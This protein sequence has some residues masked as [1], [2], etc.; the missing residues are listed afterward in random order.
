MLDGFYLPPKPAIIVPSEGRGPFAALSLDL[1]RR[2]VPRNVRRA[3]VREIER[4]AGQ[5]PTIIRPAFADLERFAKAPIHALGAGAAAFPLNPGT[6]YTTLL[7]HGNG[8]NNGTTFTDSSPGA[9]S[10]S[11]GAGSPV[12]DTGTVKFGSASIKIPDTASYIS[13]A[14]HA[15]FAFG[16]ADFTVDFWL[17]LPS[18]PASQ[19]AGVVS[20]WSISSNAGDWRF[21]FDSAATPK[22]NFGNNVSTVVMGTLSNTTWHHIAA[23]RSGTTTRGFVDGVQQGGDQTGDNDNIGST[24][25]L[26]LGELFVTGSARS[27]ACYIDEVRVSKGIARWTSNF[28]P[29]SGEYSLD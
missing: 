27:V 25:S 14:A 23:T 22:I 26:K 7:L 13:T 28:T 4:L 18:T 1:A 15:D 19:F 12:T 3:V 11:V 17:Y 5:K 9:H 24:Q 16:T 10:F 6:I 21:Y 29:P 8:S 2:G 20:C